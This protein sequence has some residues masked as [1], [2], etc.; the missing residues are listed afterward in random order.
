MYAGKPIEIWIDS[1]HQKKADNYLAGR[2][3]KS[4]ADETVHKKSV[5]QSLEAAHEE[6]LREVWLHNWSMQKKKIQPK[7]TTLKEHE[8]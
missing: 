8:T 6:M 3:R 4:R 2:I 7:P 5:Y 1:L